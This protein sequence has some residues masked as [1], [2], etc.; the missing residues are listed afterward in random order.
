MTRSG[1]DQKEE[2]YGCWDERDADDR[3][4]ELLKQSLACQ[5]R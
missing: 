1:L 2:H 4:E 3:P 5:P